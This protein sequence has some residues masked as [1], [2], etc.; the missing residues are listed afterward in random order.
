MTADPRP[1]CPICEKA[2][3]MLDENPFFPFC[4]KRCK[5]RDLGK[6]FDGNYSMPG[7][8]ANPHDIAEGIRND[9]DN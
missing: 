2:V 6:W 4:C 1:S 9:S 8:P 7:P 3:A 5:Q